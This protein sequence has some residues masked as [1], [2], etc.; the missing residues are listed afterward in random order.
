MEGEGIENYSCQKDR[1]SQ[2]TRRPV[3]FLTQTLAFDLQLSKN[4]TI[5]GRNSDEKNGAKNFSGDLGINI[6]FDFIR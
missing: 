1:R 4:L 3:R 2:A 6:D 5:Q